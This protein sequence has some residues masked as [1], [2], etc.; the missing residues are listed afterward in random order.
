VTLFY[1]TTE[2]GKQ[3]I[4][5]WQDTSPKKKTKF[6]GFFFEKNGIFAK[7]NQCHLL[8]KFCPKKDQL[9]VKL[10]GTNAMESYCWGKIIV[11]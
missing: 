6:G 1:N 11:A 4:Y 7:E 9:G 3:Y 2:I 10:D 8:S 5:W